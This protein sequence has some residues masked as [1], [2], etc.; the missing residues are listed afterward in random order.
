MPTARTEPNRK[1]RPA[2]VSLEQRAD[3]SDDVLRTDEPD[4]DLATVAAEL[5]RLHYFK[6]EMEIAAERVDAALEIAEGLGLPEVT[7][8]ALNTKA[9]G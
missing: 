4:A 5:G 2:T 3:P 8:Q 1:S 7:S 6:G 9:G